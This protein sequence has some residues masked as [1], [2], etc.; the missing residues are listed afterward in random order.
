MQQRQLGSQGL[1]VS[2]LGLGCMEE[3]VGSIQ[4]HLSP[5]NLQAIDRIAPRGV[6]AGDR[7]AAEGM[8]TVEH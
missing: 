5:N 4:V 3:N 7:Y 2:A 1:R 8:K 6:A